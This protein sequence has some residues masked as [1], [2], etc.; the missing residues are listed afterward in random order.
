M[1]ILHL[2]IT[3]INRKYLM[4]GRRLIIFGVFMY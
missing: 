4:L 1:Y 3:Q 2:F